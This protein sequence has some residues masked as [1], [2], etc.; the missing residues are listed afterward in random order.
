MT[1]TVKCAYCNWVGQQP[2]PAEFETLD[3][4]REAMRDFRDSHDPNT[5]PEPDAETGS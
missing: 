2:S 1:M 5:C 3:E 4:W